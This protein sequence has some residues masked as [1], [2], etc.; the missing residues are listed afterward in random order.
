MLVIE[1]NW[2]QQQP[3][4][5]IPLWQL[6]PRPYLSTALSRSHKFGMVISTKADATSSKQKLIFVLNVDGRENLRNASR[7]F[8]ISSIHV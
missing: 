6:P 2:P 1:R 3:C 8:N 5:N 7:K 4:E